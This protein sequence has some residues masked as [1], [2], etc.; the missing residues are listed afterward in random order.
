VSPWSRSA[1]SR[2]LGVWLVFLVGAVWGVCLFEVVATHADVGFDFHVFYTAARAIGRG[3]VNAVYDPRGLARMHALAAGDLGTPVPKVSW[4]VYPPVVYEL[5]VPLG[6]LPWAIA[7]AI[8]ITALAVLPFFALRVMGVR[9]WRCFAVVYASVP[10]YTSI[11]HGTLSAALML[12]VALMWRGRHVLLAGSGAFAAKLF[13]WP[14]LLVELVRDR[15]RGALL[16]AAAAALVVI[17]WAFIGFSDMT[18]YPAMLSD[19]AAAEGHDSFSTVGLAYAL[20]LS[21]SLGADA[22]IALGLLFTALA[23]RAEHRGDRDAAY[24]L[25]ILAAL[26]A[27]PIVW[28]HYMMLFYLPLAA[29]H[30]RFNWIWALAIVPWLGLPWAAN[31]HVS[32]FLLTWPCYAV[33]VIP[34]VWPQVARALARRGSRA[35]VARSA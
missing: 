21:P 31:G 17:P 24:T 28:M 15:R 18:R 20:G 1:L 30:P 33:M 14:L 22:G 34:T 11:L 27:S 4:A 29:G 16:L 5:L 8:G 3:D 6:Y 12:A 7:D 9:D 2:A 26:L 19:L 13:L 10:L 32:A 25:A 35:A 23:V